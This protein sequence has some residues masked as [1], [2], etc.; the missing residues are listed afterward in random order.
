MQ[1]LVNS[2]TCME[3][4]SSLLYVSGAASVAAGAAGAT[5]LSR[6]RCSGRTS[7]SP[8]VCA[9]ARSST[10]NVAS[11]RFGLDCGAPAT[12]TSKRFESSAAAHASPLWLWLA[13][14]KRA[15]S[16]QTTLRFER[17]DRSRV[18]AVWSVGTSLLRPTQSH[19]SP[20]AASIVLMLGCPEPG[21][22]FSYS[23]QTRAIVVRCLLRKN[24]PRLSRA[25]AVAAA[26]CVQ[27]SPERCKSV[28]NKV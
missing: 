12:H 17:V 22:P 6:F 18:T 13:R 1:N 26:T 10:I 8:R 11:D 20:C 2:T 21:R 24:G 27:Q 16:S 19:W 23:S 3:N 4:L 15:T 7:R 9:S 14:A 28:V 5:S 25:R